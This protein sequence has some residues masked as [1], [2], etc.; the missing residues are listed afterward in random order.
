MAVHHVRNGLVVAHVLELRPFGRIAVPG[1]LDAI[2]I[3]I[4]QVERDVRAMVI[5]T[6]D[7]PAAVQQPLEGDR[8]ILAGGVV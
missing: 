8:Q 5:V 3:R 2:E 7:P 6:I 1:E 4:V